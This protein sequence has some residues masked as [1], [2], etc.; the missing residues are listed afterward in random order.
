VSATA[1]ALAWSSVLGLMATGI[2]VQL[3][4]RFGWGKVVRSDGPESHFSKQ[5]TPTMGGVAIVLVTLGVGA[6]Q[7]APGPDLVA[8]LL[9][10]ALAAGL[11]L[12]DDLTSLA[13]KR[14]HARGEG[15]SVSAA[16]GLF[17]RYRL[18]IQFAYAVPFAGYAVRTD[19]G[20]LGIAALDVLLLTLVVVG[21]VNA[22][23]MTDG[24]DGLAAGVGAIVLLAFVG[25]GVAAALLGALL[26]F[27]WYNAHPARVFMGGV[28]AEA[29][30][31]AVAG[32]AILAGKVWWL[33]LIAFVPVIEVLSVIA[34]VTYFRATGGRRL[35]RMT[36]LHHHFE[37]LGWPETRIVLRAWLLTAV[38]VVVAFA[39]GVGR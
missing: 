15:G 5:G 9:L 39:L 16:T 19:L 10:I 13:R 35:L 37:L 21:S 25:D 27:L 28:G 18:A 38:L 22:F 7:S 3:A 1:A 31:A 24:L 30:G 14:A 26:G 20:P 4:R 17:A 23:N 8:L 29:L 32:I 6:W 33:P 11:G 36:P 12:A 2:F 34:Q